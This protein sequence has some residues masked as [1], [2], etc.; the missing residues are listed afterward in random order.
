MFSG[1][2]PAKSDMIVLIICAEGRELISSQDVRRSP[3]YKK[4]HFCF[5]YS[6]YLTQCDVRGIYKYLSVDFT[7]EKERTNLNMHENTG[8]LT[9]ILSQEEVQKRN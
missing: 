8:I 6:Y 5:V 4:L 2:I 7:W 1:L 3:L 9:I